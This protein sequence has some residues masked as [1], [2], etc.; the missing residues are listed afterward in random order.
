[1]TSYFGWYNKQAMRA[2]K[3]NS[4]TPENEETKDEIFL[5]K[6]CDSDK[7]LLNLIVEIIVKIIL[8][9]D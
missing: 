7:K 8:E 2:G 5:K 1:M 4:D 6:L 3:N 9:E